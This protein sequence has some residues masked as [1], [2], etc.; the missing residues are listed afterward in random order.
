LRVKYVHANLVE[1]VLLTCIKA[2]EYTVIIKL[3]EELPKL[4]KSFEPTAFMLTQY[5]YA[6]FKLKDATRALDSLKLM[7]LHGHIP[8]SISVAEVISLLELSSD[9]EATVDVFESYVAEHI[10]PKSTEVS[11]VVDLHGY[12][13]VLARAAVRSALRLLKQN[14]PALEKR[15]VPPSLVRLNYHLFEIVPNLVVIPIIYFGRFLLRAL[16]KTQK[17][18]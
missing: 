5:T 10:F 13:Q 16:A 9:T 17:R 3:I 7:Q 12:S 4:T 6:A 11:L 18:R 2:K 14:Q 15:K 8:S 1:S